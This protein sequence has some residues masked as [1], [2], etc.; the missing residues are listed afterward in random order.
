MKAQDPRVT[1]THPTPARSSTSLPAAAKSE[2][3]RDLKTSI[4]LSG[5]RALVTGGSSGIGAAI[6]AALG[7][8]G[9]KVAVNYHSHPEQA[10]TVVQTI[11]SAGSEAFAVQANVANPA[12]VA[13]MFQKVDATWGGLD[14]LINNSGIDGHRMMSWEADLEAWRAVLEVNLFG[15]FYCAREALQRMVPQKRGVI[16]STSSVHE[17]IAW[18]G[19]SAYAA[20][21]AGLSMLTKTLAQ[22]AAPHGV[23]VLAVGPGA[24]KTPINQAVWNDPEG[25]KDL[26][27]KIPLRRVGEPEE[28]ARMVVVLVSD[29][30]SYITGRTLFIDGGMTDYPGFAHGG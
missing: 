5:R 22:E 3:D 13:A 27:D 9:A 14:I 12:D 15:A 25:F 20:S 19:Y 4:S 2:S 11:Q 6:A 18:S 24:I 7:A 23:R 17:E 29:V 1:D 26:L 10:D 30:A 21:K 28:V 8:A 16:L